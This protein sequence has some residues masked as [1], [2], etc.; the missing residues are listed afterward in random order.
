MELPTVSL[1]NTVRLLA[2]LNSCD[3][4][5]GLISRC[6]EVNTS[7]QRAMEYHGGVIVPTIAAPEHNIML[8]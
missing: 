2:I 7:L 8:A 1:S 6:T 4:S 5:L 3:W